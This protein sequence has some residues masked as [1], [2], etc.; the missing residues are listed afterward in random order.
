MKVRVDH[1]K[2]V[3]SDLVFDES[4]DSFPMLM[5]L[6]EGGECSFEGPVSSELSVCREADHIRVRGRVQ[7]PVALTCSRCLATYRQQID[8]RF[9][10]IFREGQTRY[11]DEDEVELEEQDLVSAL[12]SGDEIDLLPEIAEQVALAMPLK[13]LCSDTCKGLCPSCGADLN[14]TVCSCTKEPVNLK[15]AALKDFKVRS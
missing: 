12:Y 4:L 9:T 10:I 11:E 14:Q 1:I 3:A 5:S 13:P 15:F 7:V 6:T 2:D 8:S